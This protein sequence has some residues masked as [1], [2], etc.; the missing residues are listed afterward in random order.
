MGS[1]A[2]TSAQVTV[3]SPSSRDPLK[4]ITNAQVAQTLRRLGKAMTTPGFKMIAYS[5]NPVN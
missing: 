2:D 1:Q 5:F 4:R 3:D